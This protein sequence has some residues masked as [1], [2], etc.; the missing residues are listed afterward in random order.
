M[1]AHAPRLSWLDLPE[2]PRTPEVEAVLAQTRA[3]LGYERNGQHVQAHRPRL[4]AAAEALS[5]AV[6]R[7]PDA[8]LSPREKEL[9]ALVTSVENRCVPCVF[10]HAAALRKHTGDPLLVAAVE[11]N[12][13]HAALTPREAALAAYAECL[14]RAP[15]AVTR[16][17][18]DRLR[19]AGLGETAI[20]E[21][22]AVI[23]YFNLSNRL[24]SGLGVAPNA[25]AYAANR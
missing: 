2:A 1:D 25:E 5:D 14:T 8:E 4:L 3:R 11:V 22:A 16:A 24:N 13:R 7:D 19:E 23:A 15:A 17:D 18:L 12:W 9:L 21:A 10:A 20:L 6:N